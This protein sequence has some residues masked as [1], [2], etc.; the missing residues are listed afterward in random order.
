MSS[1]ELKYLIALK[2]IKGVGDILAKHL[3]TLT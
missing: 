2:E 1:E 3:I